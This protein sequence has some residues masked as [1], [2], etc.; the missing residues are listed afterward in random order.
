MRESHIL[1]NNA[2]VV[3][4]YFQE[5][6]PG[7]TTCFRYEDMSDPDQAARVARFVSP[8]EILATFL[9]AKMLAGVKTRPPAE[10]AVGAPPAETG[11]ADRR[12]D[13]RDD[14]RR[15][16]SRLVDDRWRFLRISA[17]L[18]SV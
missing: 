7:F 8:T 2:A 12:L 16:V 18:R 13:R 14:R 9:A 6:G 17:K 4:S 1:L 15:R 11:S 5:L 3:E 10:A